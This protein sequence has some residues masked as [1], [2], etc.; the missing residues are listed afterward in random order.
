MKN[1]IKKDENRLIWRLGERPT[2]ENISKL[3]EQGI[4]D[5]KEA[6][7]ILFEE[8]T[9]S[10]IKN[11]RDVQKELQLLR[12]LVMKISE[13]NTYTYPIIIETI[14]EYPQNPWI[15]PWVTW[16]KN[17]GVTITSD[18]MTNGSTYQITS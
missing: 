4:I 5:K 7:K 18:T 12:E 2:V 14:K 17:T 10:Q 15:S 16:C 13:K 11:M 6:R 1:D 8:T 9:H 3:M